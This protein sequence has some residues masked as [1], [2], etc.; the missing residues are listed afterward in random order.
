MKSLKIKFDQKCFMMR[1][2]IYSLDDVVA[3]IKARFPNSCPNGLAFS[4]E[5]TIINGLDDVTK[6][7]KKVETNRIKIEAVA[8][9]S[10][11]MGFGKRDGDVGAKLDELSDELKQ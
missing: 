10:E 8:K 2:P 3:Q 5:N 7:A 9:T 1:G 6:I 4:Y 11:S